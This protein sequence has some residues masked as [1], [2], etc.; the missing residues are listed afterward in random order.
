[1]GVCS[2]LSRPH[3]CRCGM[4][5][6]AQP[7]KRR[8]A[9]RRTKAKAKSQQ[10]TRT[11]VTIALST[12]P[13]QVPVPRAADDLRCGPLRHSQPHDELPRVRI[14]RG[15]RNAPR[16]GGRG[17]RGGLSATLSCQLSPSPRPRPH[18]PN[19]HMCPLALDCTA[20]SSPQQRSA[21]ARDTHAVGA[22]LCAIVRTRGFCPHNHNCAR[23]NG[24]PAGT[25]H[26]TTPIIGIAMS[27]TRRW[28]SA[29]WLSSFFSPS[30]TRCGGFQCGLIGRCGGRTR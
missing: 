27:R 20:S 14:Y 23:D 24:T 9:D 18:P 3:G 17:G 13:A 6:P 7:R 29:T 21:A 22:R 19:T 10:H 4:P 26:N 5:R 30:S 28:K 11:R 12:V 8:G 16:R 25:R 1:M 15:T 2:L